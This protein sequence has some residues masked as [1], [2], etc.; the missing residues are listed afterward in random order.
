MS[1]SMS[2]A[3]AS[4]HRTPLGISPAE[5]VAALAA[6][7]AD[8][9]STFSPAESSAT[10]EQAGPAAAAVVEGKDALGPRLLAAYNAQVG[11]TKSCGCVCDSRFVHGEHSVAGPMHIDTVT[12]RSSFRDGTIASPNPKQSCCG[13]Q[14]RP[15]PPARRRLQC[16][17]AL[18][19]KRCIWR[20]SHAQA[21]QHEHKSATFAQFKRAHSAPNRRPRGGR[22]MTSPPWI[23][24]RLP[25]AWRLRATVAA[26]VGFLF[27]F[28]PAQL[29]TV[30]V[31]HCQHHTQSGAGCLAA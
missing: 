16:A 13:R 24:C 26:P 7:G 29:P 12:E 2:T 14:R 22:F 4:L 18:G 10:L 27:P 30:V 23:G 3:A 21:Q 1:Q 9:Q 5:Q 8:Y 25:W 11:P 6:L 31:Q 17:A 15:G 19:H 28:F 20:C